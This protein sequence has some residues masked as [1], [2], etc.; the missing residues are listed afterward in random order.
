MDL[1]KKKLVELIKE[2]GFKLTTQ[3]KAVLDAIALS[4]ERFTSD[5]IFEKIHSEHPEI[6]LVTIYRTLNI[7]SEAGLICEVYT[8]KR[9][10]YIM[11]RPSQHHHHLVCTHCGNVVDFEGCNL[12][13]LEKQLQQDTGF[14]IESH[15]L[16]FSGCCRNCKS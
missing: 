8:G 6:G 2:R 15:L 16:E 14:D 9:R 4:R 5:D 12:N 13:K 7:L 1:T 3:R 11:R 10:S